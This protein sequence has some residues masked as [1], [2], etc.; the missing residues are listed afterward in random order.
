ME[1]GI[2][3]LGALGQTRSAWRRDHL[4]QT[5][6]TFVRT[7]LPGLRNGMAIV[8]AAPRM[9]AGFSLMTVELEAGGQLSE[10]PAQRFLYVLEGE[11]TLSEPYARTP[12]A[13]SP[14]SFC[15]CPEP[16]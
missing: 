9:G 8:H 6:D 13:L 14:G 4:L 1:R 3:A 15:F 2:V 5:P 7:P 10:G 16:V 11:L 12:H